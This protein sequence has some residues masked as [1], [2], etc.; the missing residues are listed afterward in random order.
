MTSKNK[1]ATFKGFLSKFPPVEFPI[2][3]GNDSHHIFSQTNDPLNT[4]LI[5][6]Y[7]ALMEGPIA[8]DFT[9]VIP[10]FSIPNT[11]EF[12]A[13]VYWK[14]G[15]MDYQYIL[16]TF[17]KDGQPISRKVIGGT[18]SDGESITQ[19]I[20]TID[21]DWTIHIVTGQFKFKFKFKF[22]FNP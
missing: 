19:S 3:L 16:A 2:T 20:A 10:C 9:E 7:I 4:L 5:E 6:Q 15:L 21:S 18:Y 17:T 1:K 12:H 8:D 22:K 13:I 11:F 14:A